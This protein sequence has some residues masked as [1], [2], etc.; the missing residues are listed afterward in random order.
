MVL[1]VPHGLMHRW[2]MRCPI[3]AKNNLAAMEDLL[4]DRI[5]ATVS[6]HEANSGLEQGEPDL[7]VATRVIKKLYE[8]GKA[9]QAHALERI[10]CHG[11]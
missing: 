8:E 3:D 6:P 10:V 2:D 11:N 4:A 9:S 7:S 1:E 5:W